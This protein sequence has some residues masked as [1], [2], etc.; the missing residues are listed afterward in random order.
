[1]R[2]DTGAPALSTEGQASLHDTGLG[3]AQWEA[4]GVGTSGH[5]QTKYGHPRPKGD[6]EASTKRRAEPA[7]DETEAEQREAVLALSRAS[8]RW[9]R[10]RGKQC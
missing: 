8:S 7:P 10:G 5:Q 1:M 4:L 9:D 2:A 3:R 6:T